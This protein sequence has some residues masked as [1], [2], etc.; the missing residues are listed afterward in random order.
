MRG[1]GCSEAGPR[2]RSS[3]AQQTHST[4]QHSAA[5]HS[6][7]AAQRSTAAQRMAQ[8]GSKGPPPPAYQQQG[9]WPE[10]FGV[11][12]DLRYKVPGGL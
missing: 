9:V 1:V 2:S 7:A 6:A 10:I 8:V 11:R 4:A 12:V 5:Q 3:T